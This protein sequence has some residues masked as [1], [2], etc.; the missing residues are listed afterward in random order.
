MQ[1]TDLT[2]YRLQLNF[3][4][5]ADCCRYNLPTTDSELALIISDDEDTM[6]N[7]QQ[8]LLRPQGS[9]LICISQCDPSFLMLHFPLLMPSSQYSWQPNIHMGLAQLTRPV[10][11]LCVTKPN[12]TFI[13]D[14][15]KLKHH[16]SSKQV[17]CFKNYW[18]IYRQLVAVLLNTMT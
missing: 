11:Y 2:Q 12:F 14:H 9:P 4:K 13:P 5:S 1:E 15:C 17:Y 10:M 7:A 3:C 6:A 16:I 18:Y 8:I